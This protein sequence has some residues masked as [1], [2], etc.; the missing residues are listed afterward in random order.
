MSKL[1][2]LIFW[3]FVLTATERIVFPAISCCFSFAVFWF[4]W[5]LIGSGLLRSFLGLL[6]F[7][8]CA[9]CLLCSAFKLLSNIFSCLVVPLIAPDL[10]LEFSVSSFSRRIVCFL[11]SVFLSTAA[12]ASIFFSARFVVNAFPNDIDY[13][14]K[15]VFGSENPKDFKIYSNFRNITKDLKSN[16]VNIRDWL[17]I[18]KHDTKKPKYQMIK[19]KPFL[20]QAQRHS[21]VALWRSSTVDSIFEDGYRCCTFPDA[22]DS[23]DVFDKTSNLYIRFLASGCISSSDDD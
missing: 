10:E 21:E 18:F 8:V 19:A 13:Q 11:Y 7:L 1:S 12:I 9:A 14:N 17:I 23:S 16:K 2:F 4:G 15:I 3:A 22:H 5:T 6:L 20:D